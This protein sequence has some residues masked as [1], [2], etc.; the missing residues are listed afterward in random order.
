MLSHNNEYR[1]SLLCTKNPENCGRKPGVTYSLLFFGTHSD[2]GF[3]V[4]FPGGRSGPRALWGETSGI[5]KATLR[6]RHCGAFQFRV[7]FSQAV[8]AA[9]G[10]FRFFRR[11]VP[12]VAVTNGG[13]ALGDGAVR[14]RALGA[15]GEVGCVKLSP[16]S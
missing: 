7:S 3:P 2:C 14:S 12:A 4:L 8:F 15:R 10:F 1:K 6:V 13:S 9:R 16:E 11:L 5:I